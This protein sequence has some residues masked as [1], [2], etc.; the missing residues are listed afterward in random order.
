MQDTL[1]KQKV[2]TTVQENTTTTVSSEVDKVI[3]GSIAAFAGVVGIWSVA[4]IVSA[5]FQSGGPLGLIKGWLSA[6]SGM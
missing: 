3:V 2:S 5:M 1:T 4:S 6:L